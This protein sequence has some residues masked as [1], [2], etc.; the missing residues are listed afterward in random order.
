MPK[1]RQINADPGATLRS[2]I[3]TATE[4]LR[5]AAWAVEERLLWKGAD[6]LRPLLEAARWPFERIAWLVERHLV[7][8]LQERA[9]G[10]ERIAAAGAGAV[11]VVALLVLGVVALPG[12]GGGGDR[13][14]VQPPATL[15]ADRPASAPAAVENDP[16]LRGAPPSFPVSTGSTG[17]GSEPAAEES[18]GSGAS[19][20]GG[21][22]NAAGSSS[23]KPVPAGPAAMRVARRFSEAFV[24]YEVGE[25]SDRTSAVFEETTTPRLAA[26][27]EERPPRQP[28]TVD[29]PR[30]RVLNLVPGPRHGR[31]Y[32]VSASL[33]RVGLTSELRMEIRRKNGNWLISDVRG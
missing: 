6:R 7:W 32:T 21:E 28:S 22:G 18:V 8:P 14:A 9:A 26:A 27:L 31:I 1:R 4:P 13:L 5:A 17:S 20:G 25:E 2:R 16:V 33:L 30:A 23:A 29:V 19:L 3:D 11:L 10:F 24:L 15:A 12:G